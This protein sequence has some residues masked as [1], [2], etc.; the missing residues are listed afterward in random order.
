MPCLC[1]YW[2]FFSSIRRHTI[3]AL[4]AGVQTFALPILAS[5]R[6]ERL[7]EASA[8]ALRPEG[9]FRAYQMRRAVRPL[10]ERRFEEVRAGFEWRNLPPCHLYWASGPG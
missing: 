2:C 7:M 5:E 6:A 8:C 3:C 10:L 1:A 9:K 4:A